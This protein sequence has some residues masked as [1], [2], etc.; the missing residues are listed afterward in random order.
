MPKQ[1]RI[2]TTPHA[3]YTPASSILAVANGHL[4]SLESRD[5]DHAPESVMPTSCKSRK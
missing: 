4:E 5:L 3:D 2:P 1:Y